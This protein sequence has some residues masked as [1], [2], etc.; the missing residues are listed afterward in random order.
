MTITILRTA[1]GVMGPKRQRRRAR[2]H[3]RLRLRVNGDMI[4]PGDV[5]TA[6]VTTDDR[7]IDLGSQRTMITAS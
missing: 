6:E 1:D 5:V 3:Q 7:G 2:R 4:R